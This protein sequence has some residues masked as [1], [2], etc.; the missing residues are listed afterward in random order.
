VHR[1]SP[2]ARQELKRCVDVLLD[3]IPVFVGVEHGFLLV[4]R[5]RPLLALGRPALACGG[6]GLVE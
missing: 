6:E 2:G 4:P 1:Y 3:A 5:S